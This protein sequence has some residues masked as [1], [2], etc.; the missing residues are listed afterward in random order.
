MFCIANDIKNVALKIV[1]LPYIEV[2]QENNEN[3]CITKKVIIIGISQEK[4]QSV[5][6][7]FFVKNVIYFHA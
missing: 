5:Q 2:L 3:H 7:F 1:D 6:R 4:H